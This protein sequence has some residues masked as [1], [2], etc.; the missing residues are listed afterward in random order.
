MDVLTKILETTEVLRRKPFI[1]SQY[2]VKRFASQSFKE[3][4]KSQMKV[5]TQMNFNQEIWFCI[6]HLNMHSK[7]IL[8][9][10]N[11]KKSKTKLVM[12]KSQKQVLKNGQSKT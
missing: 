4:K 7:F 12:A 6:S 2:I 3:K 9:H 11:F 8:T 1:S 5:T 10:E